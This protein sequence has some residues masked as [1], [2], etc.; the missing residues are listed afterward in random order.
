MI[1]YGKRLCGRVERVPGVLY[2]ATQFFHLYFIPVAPVESFVVVEGS[3]G[4]KGFKGVKTG[5]NAKSIVLAYCKTLLFLGGSIMLMIGGIQACNGPSD[6]SAS[7]GS[8]VGNFV[9]P[10]LGAILIAICFAWRPWSRATE[11]RAHE[12]AERLG[13]SR[14]RLDAWMVERKHAAQANQRDR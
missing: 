11:I 6:T 13:I 4:E 3:E 1:I 9:F 8:G 12:L 2:V 14:D 7:D 5:F 10:A